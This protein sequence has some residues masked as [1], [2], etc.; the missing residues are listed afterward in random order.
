VRKDLRP[1]IL[2]DTVEL[3]VSMLKDL[4][5]TAPDIA[6]EENEDPVILDEEKTDDEK[7]ILLPPP[8]PPI[9][10]APPGR[11]DFGIEAMIAKKEFK[12]ARRIVERLVAQ[13]GNYPLDR[14]LYQYGRILNADGE[15]LDAAVRF[16][17]CAILFPDDNYAAACLLETARLHAGPLK[18]HEIAKRLF[19]KSRDL[20]L[21]QN[22]PEVAGAATE[23]LRGLER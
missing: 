16:M 20:A 17:Q 15:Y 3:A 1:G 13:T 6:P 23:A 7:P 5:K 9:E 21:A 22:R 12:E 18:D 10:G 2:D 4:E 11:D 8:P 14:L 19:T